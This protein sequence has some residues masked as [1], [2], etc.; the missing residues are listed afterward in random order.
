MGQLHV[1][2]SSVVVN[3]IG[4]AIGRLN[5]LITRRGDKRLD[6]ECRAIIAGPFN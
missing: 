5:V 6:L 2:S 3:E 1:E 4:S